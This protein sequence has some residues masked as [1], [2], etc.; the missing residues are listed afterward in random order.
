MGFRVLQ[1]KC[2][3][4]FDRVKHLE[5]GPADL[6]PRAFPT[7]NQAD[8]NRSEKKKSR[9]PKEEARVSRYCLQPL[10]M[11]IPIVCMPPYHIYTY[12]HMYIYIYVYVYVY[13]YVAVYTNIHICIVYVFM[14]IYINI[15]IYIYMH[16]CMYTHTCMHRNRD[17][18]F[19]DGGTETTAATT[20][21]QQTPG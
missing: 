4:E 9:T 5:R 7:L 10:C 3:K 21:E 19:A 20:R 18:L 13:V 12:I 17:G 8:E 16:T 15:C 14:Y 2:A 1:H 11:S 6:A